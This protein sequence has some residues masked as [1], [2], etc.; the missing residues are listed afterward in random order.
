MVKVCFQSAYRC[1]FF[2]TLFCIAVST[3]WFAQDGAESNSVPVSKAKLFDEFGRLGDCELSAR[4]DSFFLVLAERP[5]HK[6]YI[7]N[8]QGVDTLPGDRQ[9]FFRERALVNQIS[10]RR[11]D[12]SQI[13]F[14][15]GG[16][17]SSV[18]TELWLIPPG[19]S[20]PEPS[21]T[22]AE[23]KIPVNQTFLFTKSWFSRDDISDPLDE[24]VLVSVKER[25]KA[26]ML[27]Q[28]EA[29]DKISDEEDA[30][31]D[32]ASDEKVEEKAGE[33]DQAD[34]DDRTQEEKEEERFQWANVG[35]GRLLTER[36]NDSGVLIF[37]ADDLRYDIGKLRIFILQGRNL[38]A[39]HAPIKSSR[40]RIEFGGYRHDPEV[41][42]WIVPPKGKRPLPTQDERQVENA[43][44]EEN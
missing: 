35:I 3:S 6:G 11:F 39:E 42:F 16:F 17:R 38:L 31:T 27:A 21:Q 7:I 28:A 43:E 10:F 24:F 44:P 37:Y 13:T 19:A 12:R 25:E 22:V 8:Y 26:E 15:R 2:C 1:L 30:G 33:A 36:K 23:P 34:I 20:V 4:M 9:K 29:V 5:D 41:E 14:V 18:M 40:L 32:T